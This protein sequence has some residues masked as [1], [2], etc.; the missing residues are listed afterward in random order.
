MRTMNPRGTFELNC[1]PDD[2][3]SGVSPTS[4][5]SLETREAG[6][7]Q[8]TSTG[9]NAATQ[10]W[11]LRNFYADRK[12][13]I[14]TLYPWYIRNILIPQNKGHIR[15]IF[16]QMYYNGQNQLEILFELA[17][18]VHTE[19]TLDL[20]TDMEE[21]NHAPRQDEEPHPPHPTTQHRSLTSRSGRLLFNVGKKIMTADEFVRKSA[22][23]S[24]KSQITM[25]TTDYDDSVAKEEKEG[26][27]VGWVE[28]GMG[29]EG[30]GEEEGERR[31]TGKK[32]GL[33]SMRQTRKF[34]RGKALAGSRLTTP[35]SP[36]TTELVEVLERHLSL[37]AGHREVFSAGPSVLGSCGSEM[38]EKVRELR[39]AGFTRREVETVLVSFPAIL[40]VDFRNVSMEY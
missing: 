7:Q 33:Q 16:I 17:L 34:L 3:F 11:S 32:K 24:R 38:E 8:P 25:D 22:V 40:Q 19:W 4:I 23:A 10:N 39:R 6:A 12:R 1:M 13:Y 30:E 14:H 21:V 20:D 5:E 9:A 26:E 18:Y 31:S 2:G 27:G 35:P 28:W 15:E 29:E 37:S 36:E